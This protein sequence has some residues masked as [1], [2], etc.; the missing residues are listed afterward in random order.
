MVSAMKT[1]HKTQCVLFVF[2]VLAALRGMLV[3]R[4]GIEPTPP[5]L[6]ALSQP[7]DHQGSPPVRF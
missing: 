1:E 2:F 4:P 6:E 3:P 7:L 5:T